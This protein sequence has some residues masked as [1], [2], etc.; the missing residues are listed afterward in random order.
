[1]FLKIDTESEELRNNRGGVRKTETEEWKQKVM[2]L[3]ELKMCKSH[4]QRLRGNAILVQGNIR[5]RNF[6]S[7]RL[8]IIKKLK[9]KK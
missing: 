5:K 7:H 6:V 4:R 9:R 8:M 3:T 1:M 2:M